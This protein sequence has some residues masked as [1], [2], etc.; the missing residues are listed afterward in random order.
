MQNDI[1]LI[2]EILEGS[3]AAMEVLVNRYYK[4]I[5]SY[6]YRSTGQYHTS[7]DLT[8]EVCIKMLKSIQRF[9]KKIGNFKNWIFKIAVNTVKDYFKGSSYRGF[10]EM[11]EI[12]ENRVDEGENV[13]EFLSRVSKRCEIKKALIEL[14][15]YQRDAII[16]RFYHDMKIKDIAIVMDT[17]ESTVKSRLKQGMNKLKN[18]LEEGEKVDEGETGY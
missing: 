11:T 7:Y 4:G 8:Q 3:Q 5:F 2:D 16:L 15:G 14:P 10:K 13:V 17:N 6:I 18:I 9:D 1:E 12:D